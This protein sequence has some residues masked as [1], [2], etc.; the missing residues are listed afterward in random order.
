MSEPFRTV[1]VDGS[2]RLRQ[3]VAVQPQPHPQIRTGPAFIEGPPGPI[4]PSGPQGPQGGR[5]E[6]GPQGASTGFGQI[7]YSERTVEISDLFEPDVRGQILFDPAP[8]LTQDLLN[9]PFAGHVFWHDDRIAPRAFGD[10]YDVQVNLIV[11]AQ[12]ADGRIRVDADTGSSLGP[13][14]SD[15]QVLFNSAGTPERAT[16]R[17]RVQALAGFIANGCRL[18]LTSSVPLTVIS[19][20]VLVAPASIRPESLS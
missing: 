17:L 10:L 16:F 13:I 15:T 5:G 18:Y 12:V 8:E 1:V 3:P 11:T 20:T 6:R 7:T 9:A 4:G 14:A 2:V 19:E